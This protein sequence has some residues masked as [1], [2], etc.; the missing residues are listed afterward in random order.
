MMFCGDMLLYYDRNDYEQNGTL[1]PIINI[2][3]SLPLIRIIVLYSAISKSFHKK[4]VGRPTS[5]LFAI[6]HGRKELLGTFFLRM[7]DQFSGI[8]LFCNNSLIHKDDGIGNITGEIHLMG[9]N[10][11]GSVAFCQRADDL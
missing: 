8:P 5:F 10:D 7:I 2:M 3:K 4:E 9:N 11:H 6:T 1:D